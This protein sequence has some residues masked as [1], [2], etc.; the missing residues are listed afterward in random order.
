[1]ARKI[2]IKK[3]EDTK[4]RKVSFY[5]RRNNLLNKEKEIAICCDVNVLFVP[6]SPAD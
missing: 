2:E 3:I 1:M 6:F 5:K 4:K